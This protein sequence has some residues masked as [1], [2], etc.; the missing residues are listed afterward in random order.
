MLTGPVR[1]SF[2]FDPETGPNRTIPIKE[3]KKIE[4]KYLT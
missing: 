4:Y 3:L 1:F 2:D